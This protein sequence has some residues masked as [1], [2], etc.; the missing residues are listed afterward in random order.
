MDEEGRPQRRT[1]DTSKFLRAWAW[2]REH[3]PDKVRFDKPYIHNMVQPCT[4]LTLKQSKF[5]AEGFAST[6]WDSSI[7]VAK[8]I[9]RWNNRWAGK[10]CLDLSAGCGLA[11]CWQG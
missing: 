5:D 4:T 1:D 6:V 10:Q 7:V 11:L 8:Y 2:K 3:R 9:E